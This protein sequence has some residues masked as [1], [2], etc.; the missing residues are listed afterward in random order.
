MII[1]RV[2]EN[3]RKPRLT[4]VTVSH[5]PYSFGQNKTKVSPD[6]TGREVDSVS[7]QEKLQSC[8]RG[9]GTRKSKGLLVVKQ[10]LS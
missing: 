2:Q 8:V 5:L 4:T 1:P 7:W 3:K 9:V 6:S 10:D